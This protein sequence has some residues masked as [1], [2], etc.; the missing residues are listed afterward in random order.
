MKYE[1]NLFIKRIAE[2][3]GIDQELLKKEIHKKEVQIKPKTAAKS[4]TIELQIDPVEVH[5][6]R[7]LLE[8]PQKTAQVESEKVLDFFLH[9]ELKNSGRK[10]C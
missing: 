7:L 10:N 5:L 3:L 4:K 9:P 8:Y 1:K 6:I 2:K